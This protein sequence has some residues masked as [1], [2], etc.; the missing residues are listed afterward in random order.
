MVP[1][2]NYRKTCVRKRYLCEADMLTV[3]F[4]LPGGKRSKKI[5]F[6]LFQF[7]PV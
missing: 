1:G 5:Y 2:L 6:L 4:D 7:N 3:S